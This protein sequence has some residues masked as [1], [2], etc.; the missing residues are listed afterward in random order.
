MGIPTTYYKVPGER[1]L[2]SVIMP[3]RNEAIIIKDAL[4]SVLAQN[5]PQFDIEILAIDA[6]STDGS[7]EIITELAKE[8]SRLKLFTNEKVLTPY[9]FN[10]GL[11]EAK[12][13]YICTMGAH[14][15]YDDNYISRCFEELRTYEVVGCGGRLLTRPANDTLQARL[16]AWTYGHP[17]GSSP[18]SVRTHSEGFVDSPVYP[19]MHKQAMIDVGGYDESLTRNQDNDMSQRLRAAGHKMYCTW[20]TNA[21]IYSIPSISAL[22]RYGFRGGMWNVRSLR[23]NFASMGLRHFTPAL[24]LISLIVSVLMGTIGVFYSHPFNVLAGM[25]LLLI[26]GSYFALST[27]SA[28]HVAL[29]E[30]CYGALWLILVFFLFHMAY[31]AGTLWGFIDGIRNWR[32]IKA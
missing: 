21:Y 13:D 5:T 15:I 31:G 3:V 29:R 2:I 1:T 20:K 9:A 22:L 32:G 19:V 23:A 18:R 11:K 10:I 24:F 25:P 4:S 14:T 8:D 6:M 27:I 16:T 7:M 17:F 30:R 28:V 12:G 26:L